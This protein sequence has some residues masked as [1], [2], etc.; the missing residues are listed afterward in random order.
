MMLKLIRERFLLASGEV[1]LTTPPPQILFEIWSQ[2]GG[3]GGSIKS[4]TPGQYC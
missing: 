2:H 3:S 4:H 1:E